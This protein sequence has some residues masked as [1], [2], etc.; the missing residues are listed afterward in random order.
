MADSA[1][2]AGTRIV[3]V[4]FGATQ[5]ERAMVSNLNLWS[6]A[7]V[8]AI[9]TQG[10][11]KLY[12]RRLSS[13]SKPSLNSLDLRVEANEVYG[14]LG[15][16]GAGKTTTFKILCGLIRA[17]RGSASVCGLDV[18]QRA[19]RKAIGYLPEN[20]YFYEYLTPRESLDFY[21]RLE[22][23]SREER[24]REWDRLS[25]LLE[26]RD[27]ADRRI[28]GFSKGM[29]QRMGFAV[30]LS[31]DPD[32]LLLDEP[33]SGLDPLGR[34][35]IRELIQRMHDQKKTVFFS[36]HIL[37]DV[38]QIC[39]RVGILRDGR[40]VTQGPINELLDRQGQQV[41]VVADGLSNGIAG[42]LKSQALSFRESDGGLR[43][44]CQDV[45]AA[46]EVVKAV[47]GHGGIIH[48]FTP[49]KDSLEDYF[50]REQEA[51]P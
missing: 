34:R 44:L 38:E 11:T 21:G 36:S 45:A 15:R 25:E 41:E 20:P 2:I 3:A 6:G 12:G 50:M 17:T 39:D 48:E 42:E 18:R 13:R 9:E 23:L 1:S 32:L 49:V 19:S 47:H 33:M 37:S 43:L 7:T 46:N 24:N 14:F 27:I 30:A 51:K 28:R 35:M 4:K 40:M 22:S 8:Y 31:G 10:L 5:P 16:N 29:R 26:L